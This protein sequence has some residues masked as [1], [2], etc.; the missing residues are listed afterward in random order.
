MGIDNNKDESSEKAISD[1][2]NES[3]NT[4]EPQN[5]EN[6]NPGKSK[7]NENTPKETK[8]K[9]FEEELKKTLQS[10]QEIF[11]IRLDG[12]KAIFGIKDIADED[13]VINIVNEVKVD[14]LQQE[15]IDKAC[16]RNLGAEVEKKKEQKKEEEKKKDDKHKE[17]EHKDK[18]D[19]HKEK[20]QEDKKDEHKENKK[21]DKNDN[22][23]QKENRKI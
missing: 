14:G 3:K 18:K 11:F 22:K 21:E 9:K 12:K 5:N 7:N 16:V 20:K 1:K 2:S 13:K 15:K 4:G 10:N 6:T 19:E 23:N 8:V 17:K